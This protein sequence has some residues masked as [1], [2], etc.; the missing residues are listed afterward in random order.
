MFGCVGASIDNGTEL[1]LEEPG[2]ICSQFIILTYLAM[3][4]DINSSL[5]PPTMD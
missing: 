5:F 2:F 4:K 3:G 1:K